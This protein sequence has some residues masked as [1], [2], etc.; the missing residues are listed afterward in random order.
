[1]SCVNSC[2]NIIG[3]INVNCYIFFKNNVIKQANQS[4]RPIEI[5][6]FMAVFTLP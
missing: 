3:C 1:M 6:S 4:Y 2:I 5:L